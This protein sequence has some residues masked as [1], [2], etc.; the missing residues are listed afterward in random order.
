MAN[1]LVREKAGRFLQEKLDI[2][3]YTD[4]FCLRGNFHASAPYFL[5]QGGNP[6]AI[7]DLSSLSKVIATTPLVFHHFADRLLSLKV[8][9]VLSSKSGLTP[10]ILSLSIPD[11]LSHQAGL[12]DWGNFWVLSS[13]D[14]SERLFSKERLKERLCYLASLKQ[15]GPLYSDIGFII[16]G[17][18]LEESQKCSLYE[19]FS[20]LK[21][22]LGQKESFPHYINEPLK[23]SAAANFVD[24]GYC[25]IRAR[26]LKGE[27]HD[28]NAYA[29]HGV[30]GHAGLFATGEA[31]NAYVRRLFHAPLGQKIIAVQL[32]RQKHRQ[33]LLGF[34]PGDSSM[35]FFKQGQSIGHHGFSGCD[36]WFEP[37]SGDYVLFL[38]NR[39]ISGRLAPWIYGFR[40]SLF[41]ML[42]QIRE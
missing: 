34:R 17:Y 42:D 38:S 21:V 1:N 3:L 15:E 7:F 35:R 11:L 18:V 24:L 10:R 8:G 23:P 12:I 26:R 14:K 36:F 4:F 41:A 29:H 6:D 32:E 2:G 16:L 19:L 31:L 20:D 28:E 33:S 40:A 9:D 22:L 37:K 30:S 39:L 5:S 13:E 25:Q 27:V